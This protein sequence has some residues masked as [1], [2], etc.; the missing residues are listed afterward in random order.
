MPHSYVRLEWGS[1]TVASVC[2][3]DAVDRLEK[4]VKHPS[5]CLKPEFLARSLCEW[6]PK[7][8]SSEAILTPIFVSLHFG[9]IDQISVQLQSK[10]DPFPGG[11]L[12]VS[13]VRTI[14]SS[15]SGLTHR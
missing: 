4:A 7:E 13:D 12:Q 11:F 5:G 9:P 6:Q 2:R 15:V 8:T 14:E 10:T 1:P 3:E